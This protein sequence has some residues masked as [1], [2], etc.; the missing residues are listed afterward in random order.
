MEDNIMANGYTKH[1]NEYYNS[2]F[3]KVFVKD[4]F[5]KIPGINSDN[6]YV[7]SE[8]DVMNIKTG[9]IL[10][11]RID[12][13]GYRELSLWITKDPIPK[14]TFKPHRLVASAF[15]PNPDP[16]K[17]TMVL[18]KD[19]IKTNCNVDNLRWGT[20]SENVIQ[21]IQDNLHYLPDSRKWYTIYN[22]ETGDEVRV[23]GPQALAETIEYKGKASTV[24]SVV[25]NKELKYG[26]YKGYKVKID[27]TWT[28]ERMPDSVYEDYAIRTAD[29]V[30]IKRDE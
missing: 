6:Y 22:E 29:K 1:F 13:S 19:N 7:N 15:I 2:N 5:R 14:Q 3:K 18:H 4:D 16:E 17:Y 8:G 9:K 10:K 30:N 23:L 21:S 24:R 26:P 25:R 20:A 28:G 27:S 11:D 12:R